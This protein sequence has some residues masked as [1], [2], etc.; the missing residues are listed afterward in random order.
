MKTKSNDNITGPCWFVGAMYGAGYDQTERFL[1]EGIWENGYEDKYL[2]Q[3]KSVQAGDPIAI[4]A[5]Y[6]RKYDLPFDNHGHTV[7][8]MVIKAVGVV[9]KNHNDGRRLSVEWE[10]QPEPR[11][12]YFYTNRLTIWRVLP[13][14]WEAEGLI[15]F[16]FK[17]VEQ[18]IDRFRNAPYWRKRFG[19]LPENEQQFI[20]TKFYQA[21]ADKLLTYK[22]NRPALIQAINKIADQVEDVSHLLD[23][24]VGGG[25]KG[26]LTDIC[27]FTTFGI[28]NR[29]I[30]NE[31]RKIIAS[32]LA[33]FL[34]VDIPVP[35][36]F[37]GIPVMNN[38][39]SWFF[40]DETK[41]GPNDIDNLWHIFEKALNFAD[42]DDIQAGS[43]LTEAFDTIS[44]QYG[45]GWNI[46]MGLYWIRPWDFLTL[47][48][49]SR[50]YINKKLNIAIGSSG[51]KGRCSAKEYL[52]LIE[53]FETRFKE[54][55]YTVHSF[56]ELSLAAWLYKDDESTQ[57][58]D[59]IDDDDIPEEEEQP[60]PTL[61]YSLQD[62]INEGS[63]VDLPRL[64]TILERL[65]AKK[66]LILQGPPGTGKTWLAKRLAYSLMGEK[67]EG[68]L[69]AVQFHPNMSYEDFIRG[70]RPSGDG[71]LELVNGPFIEM[72]NK[73]AKSSSIYVLV[74]EE[75]NRG[76]PAQIFGEMLTLME[77]DKR[78]PSEALEL[79]YFQGQAIHIPDNMYIIG[80]MNIAD[81][82]L[83]LVD[84][85]LRRRFAFID[86]EPELGK[87]WKEW[88]HRKAGIDYQL[89]DDIQER[90]SALNSTISDDTTLGPQFRIGHSY[91]TPSFD[92]PIKDPHV[93]FVQV[94]KTEIGPLLDEYW[95]DNLDKSI[96]EQEKLLI[97]F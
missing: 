37:E 36:Y 92:D 29:G 78:T 34:E 30:R 5:A 12:W 72:A 65:R 2:E 42:S 97:G 28:F 45:I 74:I 16:A 20:W 10:T 7:S 13:G 32:E 61:P 9:T 70:W 1:E 26:P 41:R 39:R 91:V 18:D 68:R 95:F 71:K 14:T 86:L 57:I 88:V 19:D 47:D 51:S 58:I 87:V 8:V 53:S 60:A 40:G 49:Q 6:T 3:V 76:N 64:K 54:D 27:P 75:V 4:K 24:Y 50:R 94:V 25:T 82:S 56:P 44:T 33:K 96:K 11:E 52:D 85:A 80:T 84:M 55:A 77:A 66:N 83:A 46:T 73:A 17:G 35:D 81:R 48:N 38:Q 89:L 43:A 79:S 22:N 62:I 59:T 23:I 63:F 15:D 69:R 90:L 67:A 93:W 21:I 31:H